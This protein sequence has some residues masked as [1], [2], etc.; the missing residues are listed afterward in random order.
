MPK[1]I[2]MSIWQEQIHQTT[3]WGGAIRKHVQLKIGKIF[4]D[5]PNVFVITDDILVV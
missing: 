1:H 4:K 2:Y 5:L 3:V